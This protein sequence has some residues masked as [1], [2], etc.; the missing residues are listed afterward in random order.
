MARARRI[1]LTKA[2]VA[3]SV[4]RELLD[5]LVRIT[6]DGE[7][8]LSEVRELQAWLERN[9]R[10][11]ENIP[12][13]GWLSEVVGGILADGEIT[14][15]EHVELI[16]AVERV[17]PLEE[18]ATAQV[19][20]LRAADE[21]VESAIAARHPTDIEPATERQIIFIKKLGGE[22]SDGLSKDRA[23]FLIDD[24]LNSRGP[25]AR[26]RMWLCFWD[27]KKSESVSRQE[28]SEFIDGFYEADPDRR[29]AWELWKNENP[30]ASRSN[31]PGQ[32]VRGQGR[33]YLAR[34]K[35][36]GSGCMAVVGVIF[37]VALV[38]AFWALRD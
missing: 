19:K 23:S 30:D 11:I 24:L 29:K 31:D 18:R 10:S 16:R 4:G 35:G 21:G 33:E 3:S 6:D 14:T 25:S 9:E 13:V 22:V 28:I 1:T 37:V 27:A 7:I 5:V 15:E 20:R 38:L 26:Q 8:E 36:K 2:Q 32:V 12:A 34:V 17:L